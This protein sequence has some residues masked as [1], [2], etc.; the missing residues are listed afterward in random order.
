MPQAEQRPKKNKWC[1]K[2]RKI[3]VSVSALLSFWLIW[4]ISYVY[5]FFYIPLRYEFDDDDF[6]T[7][8]HAAGGIFLAVLDFYTLF[9]LI[10]FY[11][12]G[13]VTQKVVDLV[14]RVNGIDADRIGDKSNEADPENPRFLYSNQ[15]VSYI[16]TEKYF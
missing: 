7:N 12:P 13:N 9:A 6:T 3:V 1:Q 2:I 8:I 11:D 14:Y 16:C 4:Y 10:F 15:D 5:M